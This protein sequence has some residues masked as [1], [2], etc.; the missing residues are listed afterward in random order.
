MP[1]T[2][3]LIYLFLLLEA[4]IHFQEKYYIA[5]VVLQ[6]PKTEIITSIKEASPRYVFITGNIT[7]LSVNNKD[8]I[9]TAQE[10]SDLVSVLPVFYDA[11]YNKQELNE[12]NICGNKVSL[13]IISADEPVNYIDKE[14][15]EIYIE[16]FKP[17]IFQVQVHGLAKMNRYHKG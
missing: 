13:E 14:D 17:I 5:V 15:S 2:T 12:I 8:L 4:I 3:S 11:E 9:I 1:S 6:P 7:G 16:L 10:T